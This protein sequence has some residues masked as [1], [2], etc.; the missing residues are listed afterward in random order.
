[1]RTSIALFAVGLVAASGIAR[2]DL[3]YFVIGDYISKSVH[4]MT[5]DTVTDA[6]T[7]K[8]SVATTGS[9]NTEPHSPTERLEV[10]SRLPRS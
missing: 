1:M 8:Q 2:G 4:V 10:M 9:P 6:V 3:D 5:Y 7:Y